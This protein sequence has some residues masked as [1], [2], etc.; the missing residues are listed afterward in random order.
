MYWSKA[1]MEA[2]ANKYSQGYKA[3]KG[4]T[5]WEKDFDGMAFK[6]MI[7]QLI[8]KW[9]IMSIELEKAYKT[10]YTF[11]DEEGDLNYVDND[12]SGLFS[13]T[14]PKEYVDAEYEEE[15]PK[16]EKQGLSKSDFEQYADKE[17]SNSL[18]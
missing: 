4:Y 5:F 6:T 2:H 11:K 9:G 3:K 10:D 1:K 8:S 12:D 13:Q 15:T 16:K 14:N 17:D 18:V 7:R